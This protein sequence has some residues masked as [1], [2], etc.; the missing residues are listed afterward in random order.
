MGVYV[1]RSNRA[2]QLQVQVHE[3]EI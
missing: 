2:H 1:L 3:Y